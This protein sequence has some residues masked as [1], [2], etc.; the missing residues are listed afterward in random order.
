VLSFR[1]GCQ[2]TSTSSAAPSPST[3]RYVTRKRAIAVSAAVV[4]LAVSFIAITRATSP[5]SAASNAVPLRTAVATG[6][7]VTAQHAVARLHLVALGDSTA[8]PSSCPGCTDFV[9][10]YARAVEKATGKHVEVDNRAAIE[11]SNLPPIQATQ[12]LAHLYT[13]DSLRRALTA[14]DIIL[15]NVGFNDT[16]WARFDDP[17]EAAPGFP[18]VRWHHISDQCI[19]RVTGEYKQTLDEILTEIDELRGCGAQPGVPPCSQ[20]GQKDTLLRVVTVYNTTIGDTVDPHWNSPQAA[21]TSRRANDLMVRAQCE[22]TRFHGGRCADVYHAV[23]GPSG[24]RVPEPY[25]VSDQT[26]LNQKGHRL[27]AR[28]LANLGYSPLMP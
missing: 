16:P 27:V 4:A 14:A 18:I 24:M 28:T 17:C 2:N 21:R 12:V 25:L 1:A 5:S 19:Q 15:I 8:R 13:D 7:R 22:V 10:L 26:H 9:D 6:P 23:T 20:R 3:R 11:L